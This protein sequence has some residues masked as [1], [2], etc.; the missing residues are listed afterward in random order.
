MQVL[1]KLPLG[2]PAT[3]VKRKEFITI[4]T[5]CRKLKEEHFLRDINVSRIT[6]DDR[7]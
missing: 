7:D 3:S 4:T 2:I 6:E 5:T 1:I